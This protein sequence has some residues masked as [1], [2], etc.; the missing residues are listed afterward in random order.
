[1]VGGADSKSVLWLE[2]TQ[3]V[4]FLASMYY[5]RI[6]DKGKEIRRGGF[7]KG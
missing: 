6:T 2:P 1:M 5:Y 4:G 7:V 3:C